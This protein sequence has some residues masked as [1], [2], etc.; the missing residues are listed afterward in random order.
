MC[1]SRCISHVFRITN[2][3]ICL[4]VTLDWYLLPN[5]EQNWTKEVKYSSLLYFYISFLLLIRC[6]YYGNALVATVPRNSL[7]DVN[8][9]T[10]SDIASTKHFERI[11][12]LLIRVSA[13]NLWGIVTFTNNITIVVNQERKKVHLIARPHTQTSMFWSVIVSTVV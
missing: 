6:F 3:L 4:N 8:Y 1:F 2:T 13:L 12:P 10:S 7:F 11:T 5:F 9:T